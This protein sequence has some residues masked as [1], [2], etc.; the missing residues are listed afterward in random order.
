MKKLGMLLL[1]LFTSVVFSDS[2]S[3]DVQTKLN[4]IKSMSASFS[5]IVRAGKREISNSRGV[6]ALSRPGRFR[7]QTKSPMEQLVVADGKKLWI[8]DVDLEQV[9]VKKQDKGLGG[10]PALFLS[11]Y[12]DTVA[13]DFNVIKMGQGKNQT[14]DL[15]AK[16]SKENYQQVKLT[17][18]GDELSVIE[19]FDQ[20]GQHTTVHLSNIKHNLKLADDLFQF[21]PPKGVDVVRQ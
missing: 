10:T 13:R 20:L 9:T 14:Y 3:D 11:G 6:M 1:L 5:Q 2:A 7:W 8:Y 18:Q 15:H 16:S 12:D 17:F 4:A 19:F 21:T